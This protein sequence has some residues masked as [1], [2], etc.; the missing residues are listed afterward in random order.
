M[1][2]TRRG[3]LSQAGG[4]GSVLLGSVLAGCADGTGESTPPPPEVRVGSK[5]F[6]EQEILG[7]LAYER[8]RASEEVQAVDEVGYGNSTENWTAT[9][10]GTKHLYWEYT[11]TAWREL[12]PRR[13][14]RLTDPAE[15]YERVARD[16]REQGLRMA[17]PA[18][19]SNEYALVADRSWSER[20]GVATLSEFADHLT[21]GNTDVAVAVNEEF[22]RRDD[23]WRGVTSYYGV[24]PDARSAVESGSFLVTSIGLTY[25]LLADGRASVASGFATDPQLAHDS[26]VVLTDDGDYFLPY[27][28]SPTAHAP[29]V[30]ANP[31]LFD[32]LAPVA[33]TLDESTMRRLNR[34]VL[35]D[36]ETPNAVAR[37]YLADL[38]GEA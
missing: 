7:Q 8:L 18:P 21:A 35:L 2:P 3:Y 1:G 24:G 27:Q 6:A 28:P 15:L 29:T 13:E 9:A 32:T 25:E 31:V 19:F 20:T 5:P 37:A 30:D 14:I 11:G 23:A 26:L 36:G 10:D 12:P 38:G 33:A 34:R 22:Y 17:P 4:V 16:A